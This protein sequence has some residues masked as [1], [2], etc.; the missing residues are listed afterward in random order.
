MNDF[1]CCRLLSVDMETGFRAATSA[2]PLTDKL[3]IQLSAGG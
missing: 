1:V 2:P 3:K